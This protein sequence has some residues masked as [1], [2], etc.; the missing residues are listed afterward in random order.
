M[1]SDG[2]EQDF[3]RFVCSEQGLTIQSALLVQDSGFSHHVM[4]VLED[5]QDNNSDQYCGMDKLEYV[6]STQLQNV[7]MVAQVSWTCRNPSAAYVSVL[8]TE[9]RVRF[10]E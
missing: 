6:L 9:F 1:S 4:V 7:R 8:T 3:G 10:R 2:Q 5:F